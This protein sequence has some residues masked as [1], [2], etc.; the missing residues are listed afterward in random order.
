MTSI[1]DALKGIF[2]DNKVNLERSVDPETGQ[3]REIWLNNDDAIVDARYVSIWID[4][5]FLDLTEAGPV[6]FVPAVFGAASCIKAGGGKFSGRSFAESNLPTIQPGGY[7][8]GGIP[9]SL[10]LP[11]GGNRIEM[12]IGLKFV[13]NQN[14]FNNIIGLIDTIADAAGGVVTAESTKVLD[15]ISEKASSVVVS[16]LTF[17]EE[18]IRLLGKS[19]I[20]L[21]SIGRYLIWIADPRD[22]GE[23]LDNLIFDYKDRQ[24][25]F[26]SAGSPMRETYTRSAYLVFEFKPVSSFP[27]MGENLSEVKETLTKMLQLV[28]ENLADPQALSKAFIQCQLVILEEVNLM[29][30]FD[31]DDLAKIKGI[32]QDKLSEMKQMFLNNVTAQGLTVLEEVNPIHSVLSGL[33]P[34]KQIN[35]MD[36]LDKPKGNEDNEGQTTLKRWSSEARLQLNGFETALNEFEKRLLNK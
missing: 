24:L 3:G 19:S 5:V 25:R 18:P 22:G 27:D 12:S 4:K 35:Y 26:H 11:T 20:E 7:I 6:T 21:N 8:M 1:L 16:L 14:L 15:D 10:L 32:L 33:L 23:G 2:T 31:S 30:R 34:T 36:M 13:E 17:G 9:V 29:T 28:R